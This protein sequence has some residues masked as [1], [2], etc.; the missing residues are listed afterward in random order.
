MGGVSEFFSVA[1][2]RTASGNIPLGSRKM[3][4]DWFEHVVANAKFAKAIVERLSVVEMHAC[5]KLEEPGKQEVKMVF[6]LD[7]EHGALDI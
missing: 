4:V 7:V 1:S 3:L 6:E 2:M 5:E